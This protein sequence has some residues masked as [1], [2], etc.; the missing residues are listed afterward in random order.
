M[1]DEKSV[2]YKRVLRAIRNIQDGL[3]ILK[4]DPP[5]VRGN[6]DARIDLSEWYVAEALGGKKAPVGTKGYDV[7]V[8]DRKIQVKFNG[9]HTTNNF[10]GTFELAPEILEGADE[11]VFVQLADDYMIHGL[12]RV[13]TSDLGDET[14]FHKTKKGRKI[15]FDT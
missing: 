9:T 7:L 14:I 2:Q 5:I 1:G 4:Q 6:M 11:F 13:L 3:A 15:A 10:W 8:D 12:Y